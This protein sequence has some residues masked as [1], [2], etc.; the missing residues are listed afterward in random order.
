MAKD[1][2]GSPTGKVYEEASRRGSEAVYDDWAE[3][4]D[5]ENAALG[6]RLPFL[7]AAFAARHVPLRPGP[8][9]DAGSGTGQV[10]S[11]L[12]VLGYEEILG[13][14]ISRRML[15]I[16]GRTKAYKELK[17][18][19]LGKRLDYPDNY[20]AGVL[21][22]GSFGPGHAPAESLDELVRVAR[23]GAPIIFNVREDTWKAQGFEVKMT[24]LGEQE[25][26]AFLEDS[27]PFRPYIIGEPD[28]F[29]R[30][31]VFRTA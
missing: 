12:Q 13:C 25:Q 6:F 31:F 28:L 2:D 18:Q 17:R 10:G 15:E 3:T 22:I 30:L 23:P 1:L 8:I 7:A 29:T 4:Y 21:C 11:A 19:V 5:A 9:L 20:F 14:D 27:G 26:W 16:A 24:T